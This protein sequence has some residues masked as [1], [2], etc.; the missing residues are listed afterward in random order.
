M[1]RNIGFM[2]ASAIVLGGC[3]FGQSAS[4]SNTSINIPAPHATAPVTIALSVQ[5][6]RPYVLS[7]NKPEKFIG[8]VRGGYG[9]PFDANTSSEGPLAVEMRDALARSLREKGYTVNAINVAPTET[10]FAVRERVLASGSK[11]VVMVTFTE[12]KSDTMFNTDLHYD[13]SLTIMNEKGDV[14]ASNSIKG[15]DSIGSGGLATV[16]QVYPRKI[17]ALFDDPRIVAALKI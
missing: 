4:Y 5:D 15:K 11:R 6:R 7:G 3:A 10:Q 14:L 12:W 17:E 9:N 1:T 13:A 2:I 16:M 8:L